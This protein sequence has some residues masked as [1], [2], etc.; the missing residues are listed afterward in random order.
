MLIIIC[1]FILT[2][3]KNP[4]QKQTEDDK[5]L[6]NSVAQDL[7]EQL[8]TAIS[9]EDQRPKPVVTSVDAEQLHATDEELPHRY[10]LTPQGT[11]QEKS[12]SGYSS[13]TYEWEMDCGY[14]WYKE[15][16]VGQSIAGFPSTVEWRYDTAGECESALAQIKIYDDETEVASPFYSVKVFL[17]E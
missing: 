9:Q 12:L 5:Q 4:Y 15:K 13:L 14:F 16:K 6:E 11:Y 17:E 3:C 2:G 8:N 1:A 7:D 10:N